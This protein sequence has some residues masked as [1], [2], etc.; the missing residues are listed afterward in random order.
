MEEMTIK[1]IKEKY[2][3]EWV[4]GNKLNHNPYKITCQ[5]NHL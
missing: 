1:E 3:D 2:K 4:L 5:D